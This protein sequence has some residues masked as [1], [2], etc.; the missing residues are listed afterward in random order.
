MNEGWS[1]YLEL[2]KKTLTALTYDESA[3]TLVRA[4]PKQRIKAQFIKALGARDLALVKVK[5]S[6]STTGSK[7]ATGHFLPI[8]W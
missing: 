8:R 7:G 5:P 1:E 4:S 6:T 2:L 3:W